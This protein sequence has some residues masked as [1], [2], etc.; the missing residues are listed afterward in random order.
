M[1]FKVT[2]YRKTGNNVYFSAPFDKPFLIEDPYFSMMYTT[3]TYGDSRYF[4]SRSLDLQIIRHRK[5]LVKILWIPYSEL[6]DER[7][8]SS[9]EEYY[10]C[11]TKIPTYIMVPLRIPKDYKMKIR[12]GFEIHSKAIKDIPTFVFD[13]EIWHRILYMLKDQNSIFIR[14]FVFIHDTEGTEYYA[15]QFFQ[16]TTIERTCPDCGEQ[17]IEIHSIV[18]KFSIVKV[19]CK[20]LENDM[21]NPFA[22]TL[23]PGI[24]FDPADQI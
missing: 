14:P 7:L 8:H 23:N 21:T 17:R 12:S 2:G 20:C 13:Y 24:T 18:N 16:P 9:G 6:Y 22:G 11:H 5:R 1:T 10:I 4:S 15:I 3:L 19:K